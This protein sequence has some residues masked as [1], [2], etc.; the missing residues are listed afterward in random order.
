MAA[1][2]AAS[3]KR[4]G[5]EVTASTHSRSDEQIRRYCLYAFS[6]G[7]SAY[8]VL[9]SRL[10]GGNDFLNSYP[11]V[12]AD[13]FDWFYEGAVLTE[14]FRG[15]CTPVLWILRDPVFVLICALDELLRARGLVVIFAHTLSFLATGVILLRAARFYYAPLA[16]VAAVTLIMLVQPLNYV[17]LFV[18][19]DPL[20]VGLLTASAYAML[21]HLR[22]RSI[23]ALTVSA[24]FALVGALTQTYAAIPFI[25]GLTVAGIARAHSRKAL[26]E[27]GGVLVAFAA[28]FVALKLAWRAAVPHD[29]VQKTFG[30]LQPSF[31]MARF[32]AT[33][34]SLTYVPLLPLAGTALLSWFRG[35]RRFSAEVLFLG[36]TVCVFAF[37]S[38]FYAWAEARFTFIYQ[39]IVF[40]LLIALSSRDALAVVPTQARP[41]HFA[42]AAVLCS[43]VLVAGSVAITPL[44]YY[45]APTLGWRPRNSWLLESWFARPVNQFGLEPVQSGNI[46]SHA[47]PPAF[48]PYARRIVSSY[49]ALRTRQ[50][51]RLLGANTGDVNVGESA[52]EPSCQ[53]DAGTTT[54]N[55]SAR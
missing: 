23:A 50:Q 47:T 55:L 26:M 44:A 25:I 41:W 49:L 46:Y 51:A 2:N 34:W 52:V 29:D 8:G 4:S 6:L 22:T 54:N 39:P 12:P 30:F 9:L 3:S 13:G 35:G 53:T 19:A 43:A 28:C 27:L 7:V 21:R 42:D 5:Q 32:Y 11:F 33:V 10:A 14:R 45:G 15:Y 37:L 38:F 40:L 24:F 16:V 17:R 18:L 48:G 20:A 1:P 36:T 31:Q